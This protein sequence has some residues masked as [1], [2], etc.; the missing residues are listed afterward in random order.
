MI[1]FSF[2]P[3]HNRRQL[4]DIALLSRCKYLRF[5]VSPRAPCGLC[6]RL[7]APATPRLAPKH[8]T[9]CRCRAAP[10]PL[11]PPSIALLFVRRAGLVR[12]HPDG[13]Q[14]PQRDPGAVRLECQQQQ[15]HRHEPDTGA[16]PTLHPPSTLGAAI[17]LLMLPPCAHHPQSAPRCPARTPTP[18][19]NY[20][21]H[22]ARALRSW[23]DGC[24]C[25]HPGCL[26]IYL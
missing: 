25:R 11:T 22:K 15:T 12:E 5:I 17:N 16:T 21:P 6:C 9:G 1:P 18:P 14:R 23:S 3:R 24:A 26:P 2:F 4:T 20:V 8:A 19:S 7:F 10:P 13:Y